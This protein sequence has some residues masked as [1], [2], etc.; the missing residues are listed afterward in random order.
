MLIS[1]YY[2]EIDHCDQNPCRNN[3]TCS[4]Q[5][6]GYKCNCDAYFTG[7]NC[8]KGIMRYTRTSYSE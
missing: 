1:N 5:K 8:E 3:G 4:R 7:K 6:D 2:I